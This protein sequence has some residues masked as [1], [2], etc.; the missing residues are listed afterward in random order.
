VRVAGASSKTKT[1]AITPNNKTL[2]VA[3]SYAKQLT[4]FD[5]AINGDLTNQRVWAQVDD[6]PPD[7][8]CMD[9]EGAIWC[10]AGQRCLRLREG[11]EV[12]QEVPLELFCTACML[13]GPDKRTLY[14]T[15]V[16]WGGQ[17]TMAEI[18]KIAE[19]IEAGRPAEW[20][21][22]RTGQVLSFPA[23]APGVGWP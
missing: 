7:G 21:G 8:I 14:M 16:H 4:A 20:S 10:P 11:G 1:E 5:I 12:L 18:G 23:P 3:E 2:I 6:G 17:E 13:G 22:K 15:V 19:S 9:A